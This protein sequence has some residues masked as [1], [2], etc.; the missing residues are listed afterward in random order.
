MGGSRV[1]F[2]RVGDGFF[3]RGSEPVFLSR[4]GA[5]SFFLR[6]RVGFFLEGRS[7]F[8]T[9]ELEPVFSRGAKLVFFFLKV[10]SGSGISMTKKIDVYTFS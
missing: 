9:V 8:I 4:I 5:G 2:S 3:S 10:G 6:V 1:L 7:R